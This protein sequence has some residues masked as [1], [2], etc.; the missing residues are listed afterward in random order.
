MNIQPIIS[1]PL[2][3]A[4]I[5]SFGACI[6]S[7]L[8]VCI[9]RLPRKK[10]IVFPGS[11]CTTC[12]TSIPF[13]LNI[14]IVSYII[15]KG[16]CRYCKTKIS[17][18]YPFVEALTGSAA[19]ALIL[20]FGLTSAAL[21][22]F[23]FICVLITISFIDIDFQIIPDVISLPGIIIFASSAF[24]L[25][26]MSLIK[27]ITGILAG[28]GSLYLIAVLY[29]LI[30]KQEGM[31]GGD[32][33]LLA[34]IGAATGWKGVL[35]TTFTGSLLGTIAGII[36]MIITKTSDI[37]LKIPFGPYLSAGAVIYIFSGQKLIEWYLHFNI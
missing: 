34:M 26:E 18:R 28:G 23:I 37:K 3:M 25:P 7:F 20:K 11:F 36:I 32:I 10:S 29:C 33:K 1:M 14:P 30:R 16:K 19:T 22:W 24:F 31:G 6:G 4:L 35:F 13:Y 5:F 9:Y 12:K 2:F 8:N 17:W 21:F 27:T 15:L